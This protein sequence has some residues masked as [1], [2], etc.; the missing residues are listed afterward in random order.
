M[1]GDGVTLHM[2]VGGEQEVKC[3]VCGPWDVMAT[4]Y[5]RRTETIQMDTESTQ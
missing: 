1:S 3:T 2:D 5:C 4:C